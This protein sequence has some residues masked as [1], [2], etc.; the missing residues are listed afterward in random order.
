MI[1]TAIPAAKEADEITQEYRAM[2][3]GHGSGPSFPMGNLHANLPHHVA[4]CPRLGSG[5]SQHGDLRIVGKTQGREG[6]LRGH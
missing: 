1:S 6:C 4:V 5:V 2:S 3:V